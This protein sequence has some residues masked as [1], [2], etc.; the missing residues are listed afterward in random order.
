MVKAGLVLGWLLGWTLCGQTLPAPKPASASQTCEEALATQGQ[1][2]VAY[3]RSVLDTRDL[4]VFDEG[5]H[6]AVEPWT[7]YQRLLEDPAIRSRVHLV[8]LEVLS[9]RDQACLDTFFHNPTPD[10]TLLVPALQ[11]D[12][13]G[14]G[15]RYQN[16]TDFLVRVWEINHGLPEA[17]RIRVIGVSMP[18]FWA[19]IRTTP[20]SLRQPEP[21]LH[22]RL[23]DRT[24]APHPIDEWSRSEGV[25]PGS[26]SQGSG[27][28]PGR[29]GKT[30][31]TGTQPAPVT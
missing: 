25:P 6:N 8:F 28:I 18:I 1:D 15:W 21:H 29:L 24:E 5:I 30:R 31:P 11:D 10:L 23:P 20:A 17:E 27:R 19:G 26:G 12:F 13:S 22:S 16:L 7:F 4:L 3:V 9:I 2:P 14:F